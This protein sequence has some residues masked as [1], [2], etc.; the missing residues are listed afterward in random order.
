MDFDEA[1]EL[2]EICDTWLNDSHSLHIS[3]AQTA[4]PNSR[5]SPSIFQF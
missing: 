2:L 3:S 4:R 1:L 5:G